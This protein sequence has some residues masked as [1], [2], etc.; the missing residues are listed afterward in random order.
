[1]KLMEYLAAGALI[2]LIAALTVQLTV[3][4]SDSTMPGRLDDLDSDRI[5]HIRIREGD[6]G[7]QVITGEEELIDEL[8]KIV[9]GQNYTEA[10]EQ[11]LLS[12]WSY[13][14]DL[15]LEDDSFLRITFAGTRVVIDEMKPGSEALDRIGPQYEVDGDVISEIEALYGMID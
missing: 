3:G 11:Q 13:Y 9:R 12:G 1:M 10:D 6:T 15:Y 2:V 5:M 7:N 14:V 4:A 8:V